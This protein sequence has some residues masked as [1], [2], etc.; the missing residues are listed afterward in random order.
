MDINTTLFVHLLLLIDDGAA[1]RHC[2]DGVLNEVD[3]YP[4]NLGYDPL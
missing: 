3:K 1:V 2:V 4:F